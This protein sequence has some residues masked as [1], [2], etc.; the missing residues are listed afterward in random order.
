MVPCFWRE[1]WGGRRGG[2]VDEDVVEDKRREGAQ[3]ELQGWT[4]SSSYQAKMLNDS[5]A[6]R[7]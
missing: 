5:A 2:G 7:S 3:R 1:D 4:T 6:D